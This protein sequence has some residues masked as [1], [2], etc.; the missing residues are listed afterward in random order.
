MIEKIKQAYMS[1]DV[2]KIEWIIFGLISFLALFMFRYMDL[3]SLTYWTIYLLDVTFAGRPRDFFLQSYT[4]P[5]GAVHY[6]GGG[7]FPLVPWAIWNIPIWIGHR[8]FGLD[9]TT[10][11]LAFTWSNLFLVFCLAITAFYGYKIAY[12]MSNNKNKSM[13]V[14]FITS[15][16]VLSFASVYY[17]GQNDIVAIAFS[18]I[19]IYYIFKKDNKKFLLFTALSIATTPFFA[20]PFL[21]LIL[22]YEKNIFKIAY[23]GLFGISIFVLSNLVFVGAPMFLEVSMA[24]GNPLNRVLFTMMYSG[25]DFGFWHVPY[26]VFGFMVILFLCYAKKLEDDLEKYTIYTISVVYLVLLS[27]GSE[28]AFYRFIY[29]VPFLPILVIL[30]NRTAKIN[31]IVVAVFSL[32]TMIILLYYG[33]DNFMQQRYMFREVVYLFNPNWWHGSRFTSLANLFMLDRVH[34]LFFSFFSSGILLAT[35][36]LLI[37]TH[38]FLSEK[39]PVPFENEKCD[40][41]I[42]WANALIIVPFL[43]GMIAVTIL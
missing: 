20:F 32:F 2:L 18:T 7:V 36:I 31:M 5:F 30:N 26:F 6:P 43:L 38:P 21:A 1:D 9:V 11:I 14:A 24:G 27:F 4:N 37:Y 42:Y 40:R 33:G 8:F 35:L 41:Y 13:W 16:S 34:W 29:L 23:K 39:I 19:A 12:H 3:D 28:N 17:A 25:A 15:S 10:S 22:L